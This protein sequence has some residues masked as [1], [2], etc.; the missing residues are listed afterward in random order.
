MLRVLIL[1]VVLVIGC[2]ADNNNTVNHVT[3]MEVKKM[4]IKNINGRFVR[5]V[6]TI[7]FQAKDSNGSVKDFDAGEY[8]IENKKGYIDITDSV[9]VKVSGVDD[10]YEK[11]NSDLRLVPSKFGYGVANNVTTLVI[12]YG[13]PNSKYIELLKE[14]FVSLQSNDVNNLTLEV[15]TG[16]GVSEQAFQIKSSNGVIS[17][18]LPAGRYYILKDTASTGTITL[19]ML[20]PDDINKYYKVYSTNPGW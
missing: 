8:L 15:F 2:N 1:S 20:T 6:S 4:A 7:P 14:M 3:K 10:Y 18:L 16:N 9:D 19:M 13:S 17:T 12:N 5:V 11:K